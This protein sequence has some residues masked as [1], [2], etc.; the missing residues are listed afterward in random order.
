VIK[1]SVG[2]VSPEE[3]K[4]IEGIFERREALKVLAKTI[5]KLTL[6]D[7][8]DLYIRL[9]DDLAET[10]LEY[11]D[12]WDKMCAKYCFETQPGGHWEIDFESGIVTLV[13]T[14][15]EA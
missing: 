12:W 2:Q 13:G 14:A 1:R 4:K 6:P 9:V 10:L 5:A 11:Q 3:S 15:K 8:E 7:R